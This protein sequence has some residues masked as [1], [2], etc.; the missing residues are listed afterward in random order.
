MPCGACVCLWVCFWFSFVFPGAAPPLFLIGW[1]DL[2]SPRPGYKG[3]HPMCAMCSCMLAS[4]VV[5]SS[6]GGALGK[7]GG[8]LLY[9]TRTLL[10]PPSVPL[11]FPVLSLNKS[12]Y[13]SIVPR[14]C[15]TPLV[16]MLVPLPLR[17]LA[18]QRCAHTLTLYS[19]ADCQATGKGCWF[20]L[21]G[22]HEQDA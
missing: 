21:L 16:L 13:F 8:T 6:L 18:K 11:P 20:D 2:Q 10:C 17:P 22:L 19:H 3:P 1:P 9:I 4:C 14:P 15:V 7:L 5:L 12:L